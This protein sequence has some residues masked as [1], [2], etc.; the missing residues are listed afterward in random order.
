MVRFLA[1]GTTPNPA[2]R[3]FTFG[4]R[5]RTTETGPRVSNYNSQVFDFRA[6]VRGNI[7]D[8]I[9]F[10]IFD[11]R[12]CRRSFCRLPRKQA[13]RLPLKR[14]IEVGTWK[15]REVKELGLT[16]PQSDFIFYGREEAGEGIVVDDGEVLHAR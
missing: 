9:Q 3:E 8:S 4:L 13:N 6:G 11:R 2:Y 5:R 14:Q 7:T 16:I 10:D 1:D 15:Q 12:T